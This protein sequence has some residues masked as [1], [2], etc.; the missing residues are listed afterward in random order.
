VL[1]CVTID[2]LMLLSEFGSCEIRFMTV[3]TFDS[4]C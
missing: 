3:F 2:V 4:R 1:C